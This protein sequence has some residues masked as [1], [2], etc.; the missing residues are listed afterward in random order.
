[1]WIS[2]NFS[3]ARNLKQSKSTYPRIKNEQLL[4]ARLCLITGTANNRLLTEPVKEAR[5]IVYES[6]GYECGTAF[7]EFV[8][9]DPH[10]DPDVPDPHFLPIQGN[11]AYIFHEKTQI[12][13]KNQAG[14]ISTHGSRS[15]SGSA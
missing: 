7:F 13:G 9:P 2:A 11:L 15:R 4:D 5:R 1:L 8:D 14:Y 10:W 12:F 6:Q 3:K